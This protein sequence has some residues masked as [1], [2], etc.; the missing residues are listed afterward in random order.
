MEHQGIEKPSA[1]VRQHYSLDL[2]TSMAMHGASPRKVAEFRIPSLKG[3]LRYWWR[4]LQDEPQPSELLKKEEDMFGGTLNP[5]KSPVTFFIME[6]YEETAKVNI[7]PHKPRSE[8]VPLVPAISKGN[9]ISLIMQTL[10]TN[11]D[12]LKAYDSYFQYMLHLTGMGQRA[13][14]G[15]GACQ[16][17]EHEW[18]E[19]SSFAQS[20]KNILEKLK[21]AERFEFMPDKFC[22]LKRKHPPASKHPVIHSVWIG[23]GMDTADEVVQAFGK[24]S[25]H[26][27]RN[28]HLGS[29]GMGNQKRFASPLWCTVRR[30]GNLYY[31]IVTEVAAA[32]ERYQGPSYEH[33]RTMFLKSVGVS[34]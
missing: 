11:A 28:G 31:P 2:V 8:K 14:R 6:R 22:I 21:V 30:I 23:K 33:D 16:L 32:D 13:R 17:A 20:L 1:V 27:N 5:R 12:Q 9:H 18:T 25:H 7:L 15:F 29:A 19:V 4:T 34:V 24:A 10:R 3:L 26:A